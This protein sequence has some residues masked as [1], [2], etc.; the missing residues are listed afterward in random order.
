MAMLNG[1][2]S[3]GLFFDWISTISLDG[4]KERSERRSSNS[5]A[6]LLKIACRFSPFDDGAMFADVALL[7]SVLACQIR[8]IYPR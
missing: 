1:S 4:P 7:S 8:V 2:I 3:G 6:D 5:A